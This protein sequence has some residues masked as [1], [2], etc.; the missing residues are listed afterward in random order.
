MSEAVVSIFIIS[1][2]TENVKIRSSFMRDRPISPLD[3]AIYWV[4][5]VIRHGGAPHLRVAAID[6][7]WYQHYLID[8][9]LFITSAILISI[10]AMYIS[11]KMLYCRFI[12]VK[13]EKIKKNNDV[14]KKMKVK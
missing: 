1:R 11:C 10:S 9:L 6:L 7:P 13:T 3:T 2:Y 8:V 12:K 5:F 4:E 14:R